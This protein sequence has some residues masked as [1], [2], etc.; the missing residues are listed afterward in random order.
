VEGGVD[1]PKNGRVEATNPRSQRKKGGRKGKVSTP[2]DGKRSKE[3][4]PMEAK[5]EQTKKNESPKVRD[6]T[7][8]LGSA[9]G[10]SYQ[11]KPNRVA[12]LVAADFSRSKIELS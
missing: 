3:P 5:T 10:S 4:K 2:G 6:L 1:W 8:E 11:N 12:K 7:L 9:L